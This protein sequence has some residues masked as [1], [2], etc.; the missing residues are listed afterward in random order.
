MIRFELT[1]FCTTVF[2]IVVLL[3]LKLMLIVL[4]IGVVAGI[5]MAIFKKN[6]HPTTMGESVEKPSSPKQTNHIAQTV[7]TGAAVLGAAALLRNHHES[8]DELDSVKKNDYPN[9]DYLDAD[10]LNMAAE[11]DEIDEVDEVE[12][13][14]QYQESTRIMTSI[15]MNTTK[16]KTMIMTTHTIA[17]MIGLTIVTMIGQTIITMMTIEIIRHLLSLCVT[18]IPGC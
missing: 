7:A 11:L 1:T 18:L 8:K 12:D 5:L 15:E 17:M 6:E 13:L 9:H 16:T 4:A 3:N 2:F 10:E 14:N